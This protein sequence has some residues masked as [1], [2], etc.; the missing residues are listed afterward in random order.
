MGL[1]YEAKCYRDV[2]G[3][4]TE[5]TNIQDASLNDSMS[6]VDVTSR[7]DG[8]VKTYVPGLRD[9][10]WD[11]KGRNKAGAELTAVRA[12][13]TGRTAIKLRVLDGPIATAGTTGVEFWAA[14]FSKTADQALD[15]DQTFD[16]VFKPTVG[17]S[18]MADVTIT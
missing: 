15:A 7:A 4:W 12:A 6:E 1:G 8:G 14:V 18:A 16:F 13:Y 9:L 3:T 2:S 17:A 10:S 11:Y 5:M